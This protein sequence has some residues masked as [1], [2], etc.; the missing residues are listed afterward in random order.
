MKKLSIILV[1]LICVSGVSMAQVGVG[2]DNPESSAILDVESTSKGMLLPRMTSA[3][4]NVIYNPAEGLLI[5]NTDDKSPQFASPDGWFDLFSG[6]ISEIT[7]PLPE[8]CG[9]S[10]DCIP[11]G[12]VI[13][14]DGNVYWT[15]EIGTQEWTATNL[16][17]TRDRYGNGVYYKYYND[18]S[19]TNAPIYGALYGWAAVYG[20]YSLCPAGWHV[21]SSTEWNTLINYLN[22][23]NVAGG[24]L[25]EC[26]TTHWNTPNTGA[27]NENCFSALP[28]GCWDGYYGQPPT[29]SYINLGTRGYWWTST[30]DELLPPGAYY[31]YMNNDD[32]DAIVS[33]IL[34]GFKYYS[35]RCIKD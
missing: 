20:G 35:V 8:N 34:C 31:V 7:P 19:A 14:I 9:S 21:P 10:T 11:D 13:D 2:T 24:K 25:K 26:G 4:R 3:Q 30:G 28:G 27:T 1:C 29:G 15:V 16:K 23:E 12:S 5:Y 18:D 22:G 33:W 32:D 6:D 17:V